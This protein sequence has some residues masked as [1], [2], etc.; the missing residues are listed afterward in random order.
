MFTK[1]EIEKARK[2]ICENYFNDLK[3][4]DWK[5]NLNKL[6]LF[7]Y[8]DLKNYLNFENLENFYF[9]LPLNNADIF[10]KIL[11]FLPKEIPNILKEFQK[12]KDYDGGAKIIKK[13]N[14][15]NQRIPDFF[16][17]ERIYRF[18]NYKIAIC[19]EENNPH[20]LIEYF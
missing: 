8:N 5:T 4:N 18:F 19:K 11:K 20:T 9:K 17:R 12:E 7:E 14:Y 1:T 16:E 2:Y 6:S 3:E 13:L 10:V 15:P